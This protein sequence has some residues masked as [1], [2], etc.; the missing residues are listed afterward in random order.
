M[1]HIALRV[2]VGAWIHRTHRYRL[3][4][5][6][7]SIATVY[8]MIRININIIVILRC[9]FIK[10]HT[11]ILQSLT[12]HFM[13]CIKWLQRTTFRLVLFHSK[14]H[15]QIV[16]L[17]AKFHCQRAIKKFSRKSA[18]VSLVWRNTNIKLKLN[19]SMH[20]A[21]KLKGWLRK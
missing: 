5:V 1:S 7:V 16:L 9:D 21:K 20:E 6:R 17:S 4:C 12:T 8:V 19:K 13:I 14:S 2:K 18:E 15:H 10:R 11:Y 3:H